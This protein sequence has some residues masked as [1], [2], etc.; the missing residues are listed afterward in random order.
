MARLDTD[1]PITIAGQVKYIDKIKDTSTFNKKPK[2]MKIS[3]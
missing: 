2:I 1:N 3:L